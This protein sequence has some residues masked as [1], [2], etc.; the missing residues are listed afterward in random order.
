MFWKS[1]SN[2]R[3]WLPRLQ[4]HR[5]YWVDGLDQNSLAGIQKAFQ[6]KYQMVEIDVRLTKDQQVILFHDAAYE[7]YSIRQTSL[8]KLKSLRAVDTLEQILQW[9][10]QQPDKNLKL[11]IEIKSLHMFNGILEKRVVALVEKYRLKP[12]I[13]ISSFNP[14]SLMRIRI[15]DRSIYRALIQTFE[16]SPLNNWFIRNRVLNFLCRPNALHLRHEDWNEKEFAKI[17]AKV[18]VVLWTLNDL[19]KY[20]V[21]K[22]KVAGVISDTITPEELA[23]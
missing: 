14:F 17:F 18:P 3:K 9:F 19:Q 4:A 10:S 12:Q 15:L 13:L 8:E 23:L 7:Q 2:F 21:V 1:D 22:E 16:V 6:K 20:L 11:N 5:G